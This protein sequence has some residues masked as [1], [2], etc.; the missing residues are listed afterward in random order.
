MK[1]KKMI[2][3]DLDGTLLNMNQ[4]CSRKTKK[5]L[6]KLKDMGHIIV[7]ATGRALRSGIEITD[8]A[9]FANYVISSAGAVIYDME[10]S[11]IISKNNIDMDEVRRIYSIC[12]NDEIKNLEFGDLFYYHK[13]IYD[14][15][16]ESSF[17][18][19]IK[20]IDEYLNSCDD[21]FHITVKLKDMSKLDEYYNKLDS[22]KLFVLRMQDSFSDEKFLEIFSK[23]VSKYSAI[24]FVMNRENISNDRVITFGDGMNDM[25]MIKNAGV[26]V[27][28]GNALTE[29][30]EVSDY[31]TISNNDNGVI[32]FLKGYLN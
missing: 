28:M 7:I 10:N 26:G 27:A 11:K 12:N 8:G 4:E 19:M 18:K 13:Y 21:I 24:K 20:D 22:D 9:E 16:F 14:G 23:G 17:G 15:A 2:V 31:V 5:Y 3:V 30:K 1:D 25:D 6:K 29:L 32:Y